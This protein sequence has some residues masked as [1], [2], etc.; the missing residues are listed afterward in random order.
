MNAILENGFQSALLLV[1]TFALVTGSLWLAGRLAPWFLKQTYDAPP[2]MSWFTDFEADM[3][4]D[5]PRMVV[6][7]IAFA[8]TLFAMLT[9]ALVVRLTG[10]SGSF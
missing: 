6:G 4:A 5:R 9:L 7:L 1:G 2:V 10:H 3:T 8:I